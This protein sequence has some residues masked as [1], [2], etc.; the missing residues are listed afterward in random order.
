MKLKDF[1]PSEKSL[2]CNYH[3]DEKCLRSSGRGLALKA[4][5][6]PTLFSSADS[7]GMIM[8]YIYK[9]F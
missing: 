6:V 9:L 8:Y 5:A 4:N 7:K 2:L 3:F 1:I